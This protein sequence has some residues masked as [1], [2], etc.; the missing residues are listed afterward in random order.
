MIHDIWVTMNACQI[1][2]LHHFQHIENTNIY[3]LTHC[4][5]GMP[6]SDVKLVKFGS[7]NGLLPDSTTPLPEQILTSHIPFI[8]NQTNHPFLKFRHSKI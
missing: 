3:S 7:G 6:Y 4:G 5:L 8:S 1:N 2:C